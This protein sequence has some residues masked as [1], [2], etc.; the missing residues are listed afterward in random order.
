MTVPV[1]VVGANHG[2]EIFGVRLLGA[3]AQNGR[4]LLLTVALF[5]LLY[6][7]TKLLGQVTRA[8][9]GHAAR[10]A[11]FWTGQ[12]ISLVMFIVGVIG[13]VSIWF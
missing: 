10:R 12:G 3:D 2:V 13:F 11:A 6:V 1:E 5:I 8:V 4:K 9:R 7:V